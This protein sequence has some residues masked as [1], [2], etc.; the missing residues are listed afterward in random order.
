MLADPWS[1]DRTG[2]F[3]RCDA[4]EKTGLR[5]AFGL[6][7]NDAGP[8]SSDDPSHLSAR[9]D[10]AA[11]CGCGHGPAP[12]LRQVHGREVRRAGDIGPEGVEADA[13]WEHAEHL[14]DR[15]LAVRTADCV[16]ILL[17]TREGDF[18][19]A[20][21]AG[22]RGT[23]ARIATRTVDELVARGCRAEHLVAAIGPSIGP[24]CYPVAPE[25]AERVAGASGIDLDAG[26]LDLRAA[27]RA[28]LTGAGIPAE[29]VH[30]APWCTACEAERFFS[31]RRDGRL[32]GRQLSLI[33]PP[34][35]RA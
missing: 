3:A 8:A 10:L 11:S 29:A 26:G 2:S 5:H 1:I 28:Q 9:T 15:F 16:P 17:A 21:H 22:W 24:C 25:V 14:E 12:L 6:R 13:V 31:Y 32:A 18:L 35:G 20:I 4:L 34:A 33:G 19:A 27:N 23:A 7:T 30:T